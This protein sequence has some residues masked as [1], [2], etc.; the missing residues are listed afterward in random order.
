MAPW[1][2][3]A[4]KKQGCAADDFC[5]VVKELIFYRSRLIY[6]TRLCG[7]A[8]IFAFG[9]PYLKRVAR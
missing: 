5:I 3:Q 8:G 9:A 7:R 2:E 4:L 1:K 6:H